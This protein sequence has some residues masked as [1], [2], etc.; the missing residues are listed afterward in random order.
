MSD[1]IKLA[2]AQRVYKTLCSALEKD[3]LKFSRIDEELAVEFTIS[4]EDLKVTLRPQV[5]AKAE[6]IT[7]VSRLP[8][9][10]KKDRRVDAALGVCAINHV[11]VD[12]VFDYNVTTGALFF[13]LTHSY[14]GCEVSE[15]ALLTAVYVAYGIID[16]YNDNFFMLSTGMMSIEEFIKQI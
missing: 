12:G 8:F 14:C 16:K 6:V 13:R 1:E 2:H 3:K 4:G 10:I 9:D 11:L 5:N 15:R 7:I